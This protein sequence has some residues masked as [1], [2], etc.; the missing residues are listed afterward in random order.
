[1]ESD[2]NLGIY[3][4]NKYDLVDKVRFLNISLSPAPYTFSTPPAS[5]QKL[6]RI[7]GLKD[8]WGLGEW[9]CLKTNSKLEPSVSGYTPTMWEYTPT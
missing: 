5:V 1:M 7:L 8:L 9:S 6:L 2:R 4:Y 3:N